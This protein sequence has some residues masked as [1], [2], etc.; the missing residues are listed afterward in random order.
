[1]LLFWILSVQ[2]TEVLRCT[3]CASAVEISHFRIF[4]SLFDHVIRS[5]VLD[6]GGGEVMGECCLGFEVPVYSPTP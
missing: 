2:L 1:M 3:V 5:T 6:L 4:L